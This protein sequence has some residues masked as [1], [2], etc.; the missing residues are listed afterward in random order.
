MCGSGPRAVWTGQST[1]AWKDGVSSSAYRN[2]YVSSL[3][4]LCT[5]TV[6]R[7]HTQR[8][9]YTICKYSNVPI[10]SIDGARSLVTAGLQDKDARLA[11]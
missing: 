4:F 9:L 1:E 3:L 7:E 2:L 8:Y 10:L 6:S 11:L 5:L